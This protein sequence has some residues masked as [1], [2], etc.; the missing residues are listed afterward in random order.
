MKWTPT[1]NA[2]AIRFYRR[3]EADTQDKAR[4]L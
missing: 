4:L 1:W 2:Q 3:E